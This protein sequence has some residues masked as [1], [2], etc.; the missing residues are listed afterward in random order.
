MTRKTEEADVIDKHIGNIIRTRREV[1]DMSQT[2]LAAITGVSYQQ[3]HKYE[4]GVNRISAGRLALFS[5]ALGLPVQD[6][7]GKTIPVNGSLHAAVDELAY[8]IAR[9]VSLVKNPVQREAVYML[10]KTMAESGN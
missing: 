7:Y 5:A 10:V 6:F 9:Y 4:K 3:I 1:L 2:N 8:D